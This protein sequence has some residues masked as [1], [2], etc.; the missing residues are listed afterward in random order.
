MKSKPDLGEED[1]CRPGRSR[2]FRAEN[3]R[4]NRWR[5]PQRMII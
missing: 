5:Q 4:R 2:Q 3:I 1:I